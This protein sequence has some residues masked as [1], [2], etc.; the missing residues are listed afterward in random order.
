[1]E[2]IGLASVVALVYQEGSIVV[3]LSFLTCHPQRGSPQGCRIATVPP[4]ISYQFSSL[5]EGMTKSLFPSEV[6]LFCVGGKPSPGI[7]INR[8]LSQG[9][10]WLKGE[11]GW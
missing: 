7:L 11:L 10:L 1:M 6:L 4:G 5:E 3:L 2:Q 9:H 8:T